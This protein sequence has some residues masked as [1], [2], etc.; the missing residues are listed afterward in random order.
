MRSLNALPL[1]LFAG[2][3]LTGT[4]AAQPIGDERPLLLAELAA[5]LRKNAAPGELEAAGAAI[6]AALQVT[7]AKGASP[8]VL[9]PAQKQKLAALVS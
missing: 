5:E 7:P 4:T 8:V 1:V 2:V 9:S 6:A 3:A